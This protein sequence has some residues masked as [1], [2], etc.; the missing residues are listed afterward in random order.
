MG[1][2]TN[3]ESVHHTLRT[4]AAGGA[5]PEADPTPPRSRCDVAMDAIRTYILRERLHPG[6]PLPTETMLC[7]ATGASRSSIREAVRKLEALNIVTV[8]HGK[9][10]FVG[11]LSLDPMVETL[12][13]R[14]LVSVGKNFED[15]QGVVQMR[16]FLDLGCAD[17]I[18]ASLRG[19][20]QPELAGLARQMSEAAGRNET[21]LDEDI[22]FHT[23]MMTMLH[24][25]VAE[26]LVR[27]L[28]LVHMAVL[29]QLGLSVA[30]ELTATAEAHERMLTTALAGDVDGY[31]RAVIDHYEPIQSILRD[32]LGRV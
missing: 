29:P 11:D 18:V 31:R 27:C 1:A 3:I 14:S 26:E 25:T 2:A 15:L 20:E 22:A 7:E 10:T 9:G 24:N 16:R 23:G 12:A 28:W 17:D 21:F 5:Q 4:L 19:T 30:S 32:T 6:D 13:F 8:Q